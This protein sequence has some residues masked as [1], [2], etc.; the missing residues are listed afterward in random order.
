MAKKSVSRIV[1]IVTPGFNMAATVGFLDPFRAA[2]YLEGRPL[3]QWTLTSPDGGEIIASNGLGLTTESLGK[4]TDAPDLAIVSSSWAPE[5]S[6]GSPIGATLRRWTRHG[7][8]LGALDTGAFLLANAGLLD[9]RM[10]TVHFEHLDALAE[11][12]PDVT[13]TDQLYVIDGPIMTCC[14]GTAAADF[15]LQIVRSAHGPALANAAARYLFHD[16]LRASHHHQNPDK[17][18]PMASTAPAR[19]SAA[20]EIMEKNIE[21]PIA[22]PAIAGALAISQR[23][24]E[25]LFVEN[26]GLSPV[27]Y[28][29]DIRLDHARGL[30]TQTEMPIWKVALACG[31]ASPEHFSRV[32]RARF[33]IAPRTDR[34]EGRV[35][36]EF[37]AWPMHSRARD[38]SAP[39]KKIMSTSKTD[40]DFGRPGGK[41]AD[42][43]TGH[44]HRP[45]E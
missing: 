18:E 8:A 2:N 13:V 16:R 11:L 24:L 1:L 6:Y 31:F 4:S 20:V 40:R 21:D 30:I 36:F 34:T 28:F 33:G 9:G 19:L 22:I 15:A 37:R 5:K 44:A 10:A 38:R 42:A 35:P 32:Y 25:R 39:N 45:R 12:Y 29:R 7:T 43:R 23:Q 14:G 3:F 41:I 27:R 26:T 17:V